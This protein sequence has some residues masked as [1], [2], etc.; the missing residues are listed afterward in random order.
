MNDFVSFASSF[1][2]VLNGVEAHRWIRVPTTDHPNKRNGAYFFAGDYAHVQN[3]ATMESAVSWIPDRVFTE[4]ERRSISIR[5]AA[6]KKSYTESRLKAQADASKRAAEMISKASKVVHP[7]LQEKGLGDVLGLVLDER[8]LIIPMRDFKTDELLG[9]QS[10]RLTENQWEKKMI[11]GMRAKG[12][13]LRIGN[14]RS[15]ETIFAEGYSTGLSIDI[16]LRL[17]RLN[18]SVLVCFSAQNLSYVAQH[19]AGRRFI[20]ADNDASQTGEVAAQAT[21]LPYCM[22]DIVGN[23]ANDDYQQ[24]GVMAV[25]KKLMEVR[26]TA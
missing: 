7:Y 26:R 2:L 16:A 9:A 17:L 12:A 20:Y 24:F 18:A 5:M 11:Y 25:A 8:E 6:S 1:G 15:A 19:T 22:S 3:W 23:D 13:V 10:I 14:K 21:G 4:Q